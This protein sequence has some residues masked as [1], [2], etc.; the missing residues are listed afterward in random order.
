[1]LED[2]DN[3]LTEAPEEEGDFDILND[4]T[5]GDFGAGK[6]ILIL[7]LQLSMSNLTRLKLL[8]F[9]IVLFLH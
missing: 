2:Y 8:D 4:E 1:M 9:Y 7:R 5:F 3:Q 6:P